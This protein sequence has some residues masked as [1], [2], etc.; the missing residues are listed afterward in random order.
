[1]GPKLNWQKQ[2]TNRRNEG[3]TADDWQN[4]KRQGTLLGKSWTAAHY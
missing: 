1:M 2:N 3:F 4:K